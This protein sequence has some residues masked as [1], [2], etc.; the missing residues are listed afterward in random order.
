MNLTGIGEDD[1]AL[2]CYT[3]RVGSL[4]T[5]HWYYPNESVIDNKSKFYRNRDHRIGV[6]RLNRRNDSEVTS[7]S[8]IFHCEI[9][10]ASNETRNIYVGVYHEEGGKQD[11][12]NNGQ[13]CITACATCAHR[14]SQDN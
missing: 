11:Y 1:M 13:Y 8:G 2:L 5:S 3:N 12:C 6:V 7:P 10:D 4:G 9:L 14:K